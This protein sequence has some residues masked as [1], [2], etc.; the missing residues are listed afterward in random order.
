MQSYTSEMPRFIMWLQDRPTWVLLAALMVVQL[1]IHIR[2]LNYPPAGFHQFRQTQT[3]SVARNLYE[4]NGDIFKPRVDSR[5]K[6]TG[7]TGMEFPLVNY[8]IATGYRIFGYSYY[9]QRTS[10]LLFSFLGLWGCFLFARGFFKSKTLGFVAAA[11]LLFSPIFVSYSITAMPDLPAVS[12]VFLS[13]GLWMKYR[14][15][16][17]LIPLLL[18]LFFL[19]IA[20][21]VKIT[22]MIA[23]AYYLYDTLRPE[24]TN[25]KANLRTGSLFGLF[26]VLCLV[27]G[28]Y[29]YARHLSAVYHNYDFKL[30]PNITSDP[31]IILEVVK[32]VFL[33]WLPELYINYAQFALFCVGMIAVL[34][35]RVR[36]E[37]VFILMFAAPLV[38]YFVTQLPAFLIHDYYVLPALPLLVFI[39]MIGFRFTLQYWRRSAW[40]RVAL[41]VLLCAIPILGSARTLP[42]FARIDRSD[43]LWRLETGIAGVVPSDA[44]VATA[45][46]ESP[47]T[48]L[49]AMHRKGWS[50][51]ENVSEAAFRGAIVDGARYLISDSRKLEARPEISQF[52]T[53]I[54][55]VGRFNVFALRIPPAI[56]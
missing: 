9:V 18:S 46:D 5:G 21:L 32:R 50:F 17:H 7:I 56:N 54:S 37:L 47:S 43:D 53:K 27:A 44:L 31:K 14:D 55:S 25:A 20:G 39:V 3:L 51:K 12:F 22:C 1:A 23:L 49:Y 42:R 33:Q 40:L 48:Y 30:R 52:L 11:M 10:I 45:S 6:Y 15:T 13:L 36:R 16:G 2:Y 29:L 26:V 41:V 38:P 4:E 19:L 28:W 35:S 34:I 8:V 24:K